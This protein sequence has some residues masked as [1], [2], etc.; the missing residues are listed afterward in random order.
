[1]NTRR[2]PRTMEEAFGPYVSSQ[3]LQPMPEPRGRYAQDWAI[4]IVACIAL[5]VIGW[6]L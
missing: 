3:G 4:Y 2:Y 5:A 1:M 6:V